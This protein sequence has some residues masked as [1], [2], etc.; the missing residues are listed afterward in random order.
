MKMI[1]NQITNITMQ[2]S[3]VSIDNVA[4]IGMSDKAES[5]VT[6]EIGLISL[7]CLKHGLHNECDTLL[8]NLNAL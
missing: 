3:N 4:S 7:N 1:N 8:K 2:P 5:H 6:R